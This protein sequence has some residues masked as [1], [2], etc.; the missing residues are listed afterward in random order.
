MSAYCGTCGPTEKGPLC[1]LVLE[2]G[3]ERLRLGL[4]PHTA[5]TSPQLCHL[6]PP[7]RAVQLQAACLLSLDLS[8]TFRA[9][10]I[11]PVHLHTGS[12]SLSPTQSMLCLG[13]KASP[14]PELHLVATL[15]GLSSAV[16]QASPTDSPGQVAAG[17]TSLFPAFLCNQVMQGQLACLHKRRRARAR[18]GKGR[19]LKGPDSPR[20]PRR[21]R[22]EPTEGSL[23][24]PGQFGTHQYHHRHHYYYCCLLSRCC[25]PMAVRQSSGFPDS[26]SGA[27]FSLNP[28]FPSEP[29]G[30]VSEVG[31]GA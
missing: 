17:W 20:L 26:A 23:I 2:G 8:F 28:R 13:V 11:A 24:N 16:P 9:M 31:S 10:G 5:Q 22:G 12:L 21:A 1:S 15:G 27:R 18:Q 25:F 19:L 14:R 6:H 30:A 4:R 7:L 29:W 3:T